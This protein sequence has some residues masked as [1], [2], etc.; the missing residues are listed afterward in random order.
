MQDLFPNREPPLYDLNYYT[1][2]IKERED[3]IK[4]CKINNQKRRVSTQKRK[5]KELS[6]EQM[7]VKLKGDELR[8]YLI[9]QGHTLNPN[10]N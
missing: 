2:L 10:S 1:L 6:F 7:V 5:K 8:D 4:Q 9:S 3:I